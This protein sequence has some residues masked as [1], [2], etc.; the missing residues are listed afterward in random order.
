MMIASQFLAAGAILALGFATTAPMIGLLLCLA[1]AASAALSLNLYSV[2]QM[3][4]GPRASGTWVG[5]QNALGNM[6][7]IFGPIVTGII[8]DRAGYTAA[9]YVTAA[10][11]GI[12]RLMVGIRG[13]RHPPGRSRLIRQRRTRPMFRPC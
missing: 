4:A 12:R 3:F 11:A 9:F 13:S 1:G 2:A 8:I 7:G 10:V 6:S 5:F